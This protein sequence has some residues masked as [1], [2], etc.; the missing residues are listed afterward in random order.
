M[1]QNKTLYSLDKGGKPIQWTISW[2]DTEN[3][4]CTESGQVGGQLT[5]TEKTYCLGK[6]TGRANATTDVTQ[7]QAEVKSKIEK[8]YKKDFHDEIP[9]K[10]RFEVTLAK[11]FK[12]RK[13]FL[14]PPFLV[15]AKLDGFR[16][17]IT[18]DGMFSRQHNKILSCPHIFEYFNVDLAFFKYHPEA[19]FD[20]ELY[21][22]E[23]KDDFNKIAALLSRTKNITPEFLN[24][25]KRLIKF[26]CFDWFDE[27]SNDAN[28][29]IPF[30]DRIRTLQHGFIGGK[31]TDGA[32]FLKQIGMTGYIPIV[33]QQ[34][35]VIV[36]QY[37]VDSFDEL[38]H[39][40]DKSIEAGF[41]GV[42]LRDPEMP[43]VNGRCSELVKYKR[44]MDS[45]YKIVD[46]QE[47][48][49]NAAG[50]ASIIVCEDDKGTRF[51]A[52]TGKGWNNEMKEDLFK[53]KDKYIGKMATIVYQELTPEEQVPRF[54]KLKTIIE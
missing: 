44:F 34:P 16:C 42:M 10:K 17:Y 11:E 35:F 50:L 47:G 28:S 43:Y 26:H 9:A 48:V 53:N 27:S 51:S 1:I 37:Q 30:K 2:D 23:L 24:E 29:S 14:K 22:H 32:L 38:E 3:W 39:I 20:G 13:R 4:Y 18:K 52:G 36:T 31:Y 12:A 49:G 5:K 19:V 33:D 54:G 46:I 40:L 6:N 8:Q 21:S 25:T 15:S 45:E 7:C 41:E